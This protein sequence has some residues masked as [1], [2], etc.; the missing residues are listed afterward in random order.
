M[1][2][3]CVVYG[4]NN[5]ADTKK[6]I[7]THG[8]PYFNDDRPEAISRRKKWI[9]FVQHKRAQWQPTNASCIC[10][11]HFTEDSFEVGCDTVGKYKT[12]RLKRDEIGIISIPSIHSKVT[13]LESARSARFRI[14]QEAKV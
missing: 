6:G 12:P 3:R 7:S 5:V 10:S 13:S 1:P 8:I 11:D 2:A 14:R 9:R 4:C